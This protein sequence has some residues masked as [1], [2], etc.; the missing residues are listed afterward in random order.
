MRLEV[1]SIRLH[2]Q[3]VVF[4]SFELVGEYTV[5]RSRVVGTLLIGGNFLH[6]GT[7]AVATSLEHADASVFD[8]RCSLALN[9]DSKLTLEAELRLALE[10]V[11]GE[12][13]ALTRGYEE[14]QGVG[15]GDNRRHSD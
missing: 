11:Q 8:S 6:Q 5:E 12:R 10:L 3:V 9:L 2:E 13:D 7:A 14:K 1:I 15:L 4:G